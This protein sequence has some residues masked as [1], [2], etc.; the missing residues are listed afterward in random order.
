VRNHDHH[1]EKKCQRVEID[2]AVGL[3][4]RDGAD[5]HHQCR[6][7]ERDAS[8]I[9]PKTRNAPERDAGI[10]EEKNDRGGTSEK[11]YCAAWNIA[12]FIEIALQATEI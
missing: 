2:R 1:A 8:A 4:R 12:D 7:G 11:H 6:A 5:G 9:E 3:F 10:S